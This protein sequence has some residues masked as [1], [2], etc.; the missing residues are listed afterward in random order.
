MRTDNSILGPSRICMTKH[1]RN[2]ASNIFDKHNNNHLVNVKAF[3][4]LIPLLLY[5]VVSLTVT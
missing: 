3:V 4:L 5:G 2:L 1:E